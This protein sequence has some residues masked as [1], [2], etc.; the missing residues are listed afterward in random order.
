[1]L[2]LVPIDVTKLRPSGANAIPSSVATPNVTCSGL[3]SG[4]RCRQMW[5][6]SVVLAVKYIQLPSGDQ[7]ASVHC[8]G[9]GPTRVPCDAPSMGINR[10]G[11][12][13]RMSISATSTDF[14]SGDA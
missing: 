4:K 12:H 8:A 13:E 5:I 10:H 2:W 7:A 9:V 3:P 6:P 14:P 11:S 1:M